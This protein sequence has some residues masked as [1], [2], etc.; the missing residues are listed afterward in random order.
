MGVCGIFIK[1]Y[2]GGHEDTGLEEKINL[3]D[4][5]IQNPEFTRL[6]N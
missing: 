5:S 3:W 6:S 2:E 4:Y 1:Y